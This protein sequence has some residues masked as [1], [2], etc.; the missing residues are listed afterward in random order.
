MQGH[1]EENN[2]FYK[3]HMKQK[4]MEENYRMQQQEA[5]STP[6]QAAKKIGVS[7]SNSRKQIITMMANK[8][9]HNRNSLVNS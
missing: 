4:M 7:G 1:L 9:T 8:N 6:E 2:K 3:D 5:S